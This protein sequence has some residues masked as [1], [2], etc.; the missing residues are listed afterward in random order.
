MNALVT[1]R[2]HKLS[3]SL[4]EL[5]LKV[6]EAMATELASAVGTAVRDILVVAILDRIV[7][8]PSRTTPTP[9]H[10]GTWR[11]DGYDRWGE[12][13]DPWGDTDEED[14]PATSRDE[15]DDGDDEGQPTAVPALA[16]IAVGVNVGR[17][18]LAR[19]G[20][21]PTAIGFGM[22][23]T[24]LGFAGGPFAQAALAV[25]AAT[26]DLMTAESALSRA[27]PS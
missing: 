8:I 1:N 12:P 2:V 26:S 22:V 18:W 7:N 20:T 5:K 24:A 11:H 21:V 25:L 10:A 27:D 3:E 16:A 6:R 19:K 4:V 15:L 9:A 13:K 14:R 23:A 17:W